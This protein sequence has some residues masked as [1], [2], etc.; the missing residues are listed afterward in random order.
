MAHAFI[1]RTNVETSVDWISPLLPSL[2]GSSASS[3]AAETWQI[4]Y[5]LEQIT[6]FNIRQSRHFRIAHT[7]ENRTSLW[8]VLI[9]YKEDHNNLFFLARASIQLLRPLTILKQ[10]SV[11]CFWLKLHL[12]CITFINLFTNQKRQIE[13]LVSPPII[14]NQLDP[15]FCSQGWLENLQIP[16]WQGDRSCHRS[17]FCK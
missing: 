2:R 10:V 13:G 15:H 4:A 14:Y 16:S 8:F 6:I 11:Y 17:F 12:W 3:Q 7:V 5:S 9:P 1:L